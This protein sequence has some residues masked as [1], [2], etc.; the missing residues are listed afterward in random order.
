[1][2]SRKLDTN[3]GKVTCG[4]S[5]EIHQ[6]SSLEDRGWR[7]ADKVQYEFPIYNVLDVFEDIWQRF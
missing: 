4:K 5:E 3:S 1:M 6:N 2:P 7:D